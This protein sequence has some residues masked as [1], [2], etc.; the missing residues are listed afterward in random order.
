M[1]EERKRW[2]DYARAMGIILV[3]AGH[4]YQDNIVVDWL[5]SFHMPLFF[6]LSGITIKRINNK[7]DFVEFTKRRIVMLLV[8][9]LGYSVLNFLYNC[10][11]VSILH[12]DI[13]LW[14]NI[15]GIIV[16]L[17]G[18]EYSLGVWFL[19]LLFLG[20]EI[21][22]L[23]MFAC[24]KR[25]IYE[26][27]MVMALTIGGYLYNYYCGSI[28]PWGID[29]IH[30][31]VLFLFIGTQ[32]GM[33]FD[34][35]LRKK[36]GNIYMFLSMV[37]AVNCLTAY[38]NYKLINANVDLYTETFGNYP[39]YIIAA[40]SGVV[41][42]LGISVLMNNLNSRVLSYVGKNTLHIYG[43]HAL[44]IGVLKKVLESKV[45][46]LSGNEMIIIVIFMTVVTLLACL[47]AIFTM[48]KVWRFI[49]QA[50]YRK[51]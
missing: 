5:Y 35:T 26:Y 49:C 45:N 6:L 10:L 38:M 32:L 22:A 24:K 51:I 28:L 30:V 25:I 31:V 43:M 17:R 50:K 19:P 11:Q 1:K 13:N 47:L 29:V 33:K 44:I 48:K 39:L 23:I 18:S 12:K 2:I 34:Y 21:I 27:I 7:V 41:F 46:A 37:L 20:E 36:V 8:P 4:T 9:Y 16:Q 15:L 40:I 3:V 14:K 42:V